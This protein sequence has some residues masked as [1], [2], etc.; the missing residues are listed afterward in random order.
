MKFAI[1][2]FVACFLSCALITHAQ[3][4]KLDDAAIEQILKKY[5]E[6]WVT[7]DPKIRRAKLQEVWVEKATHESPFGLS[8]GRDAIDNEIDGFIKAYPNVTIQLTVLQRTGNNLLCNFVVNKPD[9]S[10]LFRGIDY[11]ELTETGLLKKAV[12]FVQQQGN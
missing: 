12:G 5:S 7:A 9:G 1:K 3:P 4:P 6:V 2:M 8:D 10:L 11:F